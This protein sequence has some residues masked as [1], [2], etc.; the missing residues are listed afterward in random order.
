MCSKL[1]KEGADCKWRGAFSVTGSMES[2]VSD[3]KDFIDNPLSKE[4]VRKAIANVTNVPAEYVDVDLFENAN[5]SRRLLLQQV[6]M[7]DALLVTYAIA[8]GSDAP[9]SVKVTGEEVSS[10]MTSSNSGT[11]SDAITSKVDESFGAGV[12]A[13]SVQTVNTPDVTVAPSELST[14][15]T[16]TVGTSETTTASAQSTTV[17]LEATTSVTSRNFLQADF[18]SGAFGIVSSGLHMI[19]VVLLLGF[20]Q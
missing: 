10:K 4:A 5:Q 18:E 12:F 1:E 20:F 15:T 2:S 7:Q 14:S 8:V 9:A 6:G 16:S 11:I 13:V 17:T 3:A 19:A